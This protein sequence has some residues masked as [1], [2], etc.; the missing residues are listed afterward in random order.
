M[1]MYIY[2]GLITAVLTLPTLAES[3]IDDTYDKYQAEMVTNL[4]VLADIDKAAWS[5]EMK[6]PDLDTASFGEQASLSNQAIKMV[7]IVDQM[8]RRSEETFET[9][10]G[11]Y[12]LFCLQSS[13]YLLLCAEPRHYYKLMISDTIVLGGIYQDYR[14]R[15][16]EILTA[17]GR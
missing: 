15:S 4:E 17:L 3:T 10:Q 5:I 2:A 1:R 6:Y 8:R 11:Q 7:A 16:I 9:I 13:T 12:E 14:E